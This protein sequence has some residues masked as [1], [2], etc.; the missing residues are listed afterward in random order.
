MTLTAID[1]LDD[2]AALRLHWSDGLTARFHA[3]WL[4][5][6]ALDPQT[7]S[8]TNGQRLITILDV[9]ANVCVARAS[10]RDDG[11]ISVILAPE[12]REF[13]FTADWLREHRYDGRTVQEDAW[14]EPL[15][16]TW[17]GGLTAHRP[18][19]CWPEVASNV[20]ALG[21][22][23]A[24]VRRYGFAILTEVPTVSGQVCR[25]AERFG[26][27]RETNYGRWF[28]VRSEVNPSNLAF[29]NAGLQPHTDNPYRDPV[30]TL[31]LL[32]CLENSVQG[33]ESLVIDGFRAAQRLRESNPRAFELLSGHCARFE[34]SGQRDVLLK[35]RR[36]MIELA[37]DGE[38]IAV[39]FN[40]RS[41]A[42]FSDIP[43][44]LMQEFYAASR[45][46]AAIVEAP[47]LAVTFRL[48]PG[49]LFVV[50][51]TRVLHAREEF[52]GSGTR[53]L[54]GCYADKDGLLSTL[55][56]IE[57]RRQAGVAAGPRDR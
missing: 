29:T 31:Q 37:P 50:D 14:L 35:A 12:N 7:R 15:V 21:D 45:Q 9:S 13:T 36:P 16:E 55:A 57:N 23:L 46:F 48:A 26:Y 32:C 19:G 53:W 22:W 27:V 1:I 4:R 56:V 3:V 10:L 52:S 40:N 42:P 25:V 28:D 17:D 34:F 18:V 38:L 24:A 11:G 44:D 39:R 43:Y 51:N 2:G 20:D 47:D 54:Q 5:D 8:P 49:E 30:P 6:A 33:G 41:A